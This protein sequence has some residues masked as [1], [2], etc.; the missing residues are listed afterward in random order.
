MMKFKKNLLSLLLLAA[1]LLTSCAQAPKVQ[2][3]TEPPSTSPQTEAPA[4]SD[5]PLWEVRKSDETW[6]SYGLAAYESGKE[7]SDLSVFFS[8]PS[9]MVYLTLF[10][11]MFVYDKESSLPVAEALF[12][13]VYDTYGADALTDLDRRVE[14]K[15]A[16]LQSLGLDQTYINPL[17]YEKM[18]AQMK[19]SSTKDYPYVITLDNTTYYYKDFNAGTISQYHA[20]MY[21][22]TTAISELTDF[23][24]KNQ[25]EDHFQTGIHLRYY[26]TFEVG[27]P[28]YTL[29]NG[30]IYIND[31]SA[32]LHETMHAMGIGK[33]TTEHIWLSEG[34]SDYFGKILNFNEQIAAGSIQIINAANQGYFDAGAEKGDPASIRYKRISKEYL[35]KGG[36]I[37]L[38]IHFD[39]RLY[40]DLI[41]H[42]ELE[43]GTFVTL[44]ETY[45][46]VNDK[47]SK[48]TGR[49]LSYSQAASLVA[50]LADTY[51]IDQVLKA[52][53]SQSTAV[54]GKSYE[55]LKA[56]WWQYLQ[57]V[58]A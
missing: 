24:K 10:E 15:T 58:V 29:S 54:F 43:M 52:Y 21:Y 57:G 42:A 3:N 28:S 11:D 47:E 56:L 32:L 41:A 8:T 36:R 25:I 38:A 46:K 14:L 12:K 4:P 19:L 23:L 27:Q 20:V 34:L 9:N 45:D 7:I 17:D 13:F 49:E 35:E 30:S 1:I 31:S 26:M 6:L 16:F 50:Y 18:M 33:K 39:M 44:G 55:E 53:E 22:N 48:H 40:F 2:S 37:D 5:D 51:G